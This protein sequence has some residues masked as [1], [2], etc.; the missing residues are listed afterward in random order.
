MRNNDK[1]KIYKYEYGTQSALYNKECWLH[2]SWYLFIVQNLPVCSL[3]EEIF[4]VLL[5]VFV[6]ALHVHPEICVG[7]H[8]PIIQFLHF[9]CELKKQIK[10]SFAVN[11]LQYILD[12]LMNHGIF[13]IC[14]GFI[15]CWS[16]FFM[17][18]FTSS[19]NYEKKLLK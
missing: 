2:N 5:F 4:D 9:L 7:T 8:R 17:H 6:P 14:G 1:N 12:S 19:I 10:V 18:K 16:S 13:K 11:L 3:Y 15:F